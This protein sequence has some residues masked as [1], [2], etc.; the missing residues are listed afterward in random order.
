M[1]GLTK[2]QWNVSEGLLAPR[3]SVL[4]AR[5]ER[6]GNEVADEGHLASCLGF[7]FRRPSWPAPL[8]SGPDVTKRCSDLYSAADVYQGLDA[9]NSDLST[10]RVGAEDFAGVQPSIGDSVDRY[11][12]LA[13]GNADLFKADRSGSSGAGSDPDIYASVSGNPDLQF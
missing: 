13:D 3:A 9:G 4:K 5:Y 11:H 7:D 8:I 2:R 10:P 6:S 12:G 1:S